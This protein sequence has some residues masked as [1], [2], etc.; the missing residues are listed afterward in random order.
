MCHCLIEQL[1]CCGSFE[2]MIQERIDAWDRVNQMAL[3]NPLVSIGY[4]VVSVKLYSVSV[5]VC[6]YVYVCVCVC[7][8][9]DNSY[10]VLCLLLHQLCK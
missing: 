6:V 9:D 7:V 8:C 1:E 4:Y 2:T 3:E 5:S 10:F